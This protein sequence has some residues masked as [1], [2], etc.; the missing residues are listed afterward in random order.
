MERRDLPDISPSADTSPV[1]DREM[2]WVQENYS[3]LA[4]KYGGQWIA[5][6]DD[7]LIAHGSLEEVSRTLDEQGVKDP[8]VQRIPL[9]GE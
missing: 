3:E 6:S 7:S 5:V 8:F 1:S 9:Q 4:E 2:H